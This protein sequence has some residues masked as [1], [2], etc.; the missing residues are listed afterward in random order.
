MISLGSSTSE[1]AMRDALALAA[2]EL[3]RPAAARGVGVDADGLEHLVDLG[4]A[5]RPSVPRFQIVE[6][7]GDDVADLAA[8]VQ[9]RDRVLEDHLHLGCGP[10]AASSPESAVRSLAVEA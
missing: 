9:R 5:A 1:R 10:R 4:V 3:V 6:R 7:L 2:G 8:R